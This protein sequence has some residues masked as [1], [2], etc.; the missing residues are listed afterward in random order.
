ML[1]RMRRRTRAA[2]DLASVMVGVA[3][4]ALLAGTIG[5]AVFAVIPWAQDESAK[6][7][8]KAVVI[9][10]N[11]ARMAQPGTP[12]R[13]MYLQQNIPEAT[14]TLESE[15]LIEHKDKVVVDIASGGNCYVGMSLSQSGKTFWVDDT[16][17]KTHWLEEPDRTTTCPVD[18]DALKA[19]IPT[20]GPKDPF[21]TLSV[22]DRT[23]LTIN[24]TLAAL[25]DDGKVIYAAAAS[26]YIHV[27][28]DTGI[29]WTA[30]T[31]AGKLAWY[32]LK[33]TSN[34]KK[35]I[36]SVNGGNLYLSNDTG[37]TWNPITSAGTNPWAGVTISD[38]GQTLTAAVNTANGTVWNSFD[39]GAT[40]TTG[41]KTGSW[42]VTAI[43]DDG[44]KMA[45][46]INNSNIFTSTDRGKT[47][48]QQAGSPTKAWTALASSADGQ[49]LVAGA[50]ADVLYKS[51]DG[52]VT[53]TPLTNSGS[54]PWSSVSI[55]GQHLVAAESGAAGTVWYSS[56]GGDTWTTGSKTAS[57]SATATSA[58]GMKLIAG[59]NSGTLYTSSDGGV[60]W[61]QRASSGTATWTGISMS[62]TGTYAAAATTGGYIYTSTDSGVTWTQQTTSGSRNWWDVLVA[63]DGLHITAAVSNGGTFVS[64]DFGATWA[65]SSGGP[66]S[67]SYYLSGSTTGQKQALG[68]YSAGYVSNNYGA[69]WTNPYSGTSWNSI[70]ISG[71][72]NTVWGTQNYNND[73]IYKSANGGVTW[74]PVTAPWSPTVMYGGTIA[75]S[76][77]GQRVVA[78]G[79]SNSLWASTNGGTTWTALP[80]P[81]GASKFHL[82]ADGTTIIVSANSGVHVSHD[83]GATWHTGAGT[84]SSV[85]YTR[86]KASTD[87]RQVLATGV[88]ALVSSDYGATWRS[89]NTSY[90]TNGSAVSG[91]GMTM[92]IGTNCNCATV[93]KSVDA[94]ATWANVTAS[95]SP[96]NAYARLMG[97]SADG[98]KVYQ[99]S[100]ASSNVKASADGGATWATKVSPGAPT[101][102]SVSRDGS[103][104]VATASS[105]VYVSTDDGTSWTTGAGNAASGYRFAAGSDDGATQ[106][107]AWTNGTNISSVNS[108]RTWTAYSPCCA[109][110][111]V[112]ISGD[113]KHLWETNN[114]NTGGQISHSA[115]RGRTWSAVTAPW[116][117][118]Y[119]DSVDVSDDGTTVVVGGRTLAAYKS[120]D[121]GVTWTALPL[122]NASW[123]AIRMSGDGKVMVAGSNGLRI[124]RDGGVNWSAGAGNAAGGSWGAASSAD[125][126]TQFFGGSGYGAVSRDNGATWSKTLSTSNV[127]YSSAISGDATKMLAGLNVYTTNLYRSTDSGVTW[128]SFNAPWA[129]SNGYGAAAAYSVDG[130]KLVVGN[131][132]GYLY[133]ST[134]NGTTWTKLT[135]AG[136][137]SWQSLDMSA[138]GMKIVATAA[139]ANNIYVSTDFGVTWNTVG[140]SQSW[141]AARFANNAMTI[142]AAATSKDIY[143]SP[144]FGATWPTVPS[145]SNLWTSVDSSD[146]GSKLVA[147][148]SDGKV[149][150]SKNSGVSW[151]TL[152]VPGAVSFASVTVTGDGKHA[153]VAGAGASNVALTVT[154]DYAA[155]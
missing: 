86:I 35:A 45:A 40:W 98:Q 43:S 121:S 11:T 122:G 118:G 107:A 4:V 38:D 85:G 155:G 81:P 126:K 96:T 48:T 136:S 9:A 92:W 58:D 152:A 143:V 125:G 104:I 23:G 67:G 64:A 47:W 60:T 146:D 30:A 137:R 91:D 129:P 56:D 68:G 75:T 16:S 44:T 112:A 83:F 130:S 28:T 24:P 39:G 25:S 26:Q 51:T 99:W 3:V 80:T 65:A 72:G 73:K 133:T 59:I 116:G 142:I 53:W 61:T 147:V 141:K 139:G 12:G 134:D 148:T 19:K 13:T 2:I 97:V 114:N 101:S 115:D 15:H 52:G 111:D 153:T 31:S 41:S 6:N 7:D 106:L 123:N 82:S 120:T 128:A 10:E 88:G 42:T 8:L 36:A 95:W 140:A 1:H 37:K 62:S 109:S 105:A 22:T 138:D 34:G 151:A 119:P 150:S 117:T 29:S 55:A 46:A 149:F 27:S 84:G 76:A 79:P 89:Y 54:R 90:D 71:D 74:N 14:V 78:A 21:A 57:W 135:S 63:E 5:A 70:A 87:G 102:V 132:G 50:P 144:D 110:V 127:T 94:G 100:S 69:T 93:M 124:S 103:T 32:D 17:Q 66:T 113:G 18:L 33:T 154:L 108:G 77:D 131:N 20:N 49:T 145:G